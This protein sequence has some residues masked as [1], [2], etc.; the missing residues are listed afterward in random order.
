MNGQLLP[1]SDWQDAAGLQRVVLALK[2]GNGGP[3]IVGG[4]VRDTLLGLDVTDVDLATMLPPEI[5]VD[6]LVA[7]GIKAVPTGIDHGTITAIAEGRSYEITTLRSDVTT[8]GRRATVAFAKD[9]REDAARRDFTINALYADPVSGEIFD[10]VNGLDDL[11]SGVIKFIGDAEQRIAED[12][13]RILRFFRFLARFGH[14]EVDPVALRACANAAHGLTALSRERIA[15][16][17]VKIMSLSNP[18]DVVAMMAENG[19]FAPFLPELSGNAANDLSRLVNR[20]KQLGRPASLTARLLTLLPKNAVMVDKVAARLKL[21]NRLRENLAARLEAPLPTPANIR[22]LAYHAGI[23]CA[24]DAA[25]LYADEEDLQECLAMLE[26]WTVPKFPIKGGDLIKMGLPI[27]PRVAK[28][29]QL[30]ESRWVN[31]SFPDE[32]RVREIADQLVI[33]ALSASKNA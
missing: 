18:V 3:R 10:Y 4:A 23:D 2:D 5:V 29:L 30:L 24:Y 19:I 11:N 7:A 15:Q 9:W 31:E 6:R 8:D 12:Y 14:G 32:P 20:E 22:A 33:E 17:I 27:G 26:S 25:L 21:S 16:E 13:L 1:K 28:T